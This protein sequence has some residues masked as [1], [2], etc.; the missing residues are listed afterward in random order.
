MPNPAI[1][2]DQVHTLAEACSDAGET[3]QP[4]AARLLREQR[5]LGRF[6][7]RNAS[8]LG[9]QA[10][11]S[12]VYM[13]AVTVRIFE[14]VGG[15]LKDVTHADLDA[16]AARVATAVDGLLPADEGVPGRLRAVP[17]RAQPHLL[18]EILWALY[19]KEEK[20]EGEVRVEPPEA[21]LL[22]LTLWAIVEALDAR[23][24][25]PSGY[26]GA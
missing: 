11:Q 3:F 16:A 21:F 7:E 24:T 18:D 19:E 25:P 26:V 4:T 5:R 1:P 12:A 17:W 14:Q 22:L 20:A 15:R 9:A 10:A 23:W 6:I 2:R 13:C 8:S